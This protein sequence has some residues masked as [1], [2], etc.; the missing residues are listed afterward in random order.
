MAEQSSVITRWEGNKFVVSSHLEVIPGKQD[1]Y[2]AIKDY[3]VA[4]NM[5][6]T[7]ADFGGLKFY[8]EKLIRA[9]MPSGELFSAAL[10]G[11]SAD[12]INNSVADLIQESVPWFNFRGAEAEYI[13]FGKRR[14]MNMAIDGITPKTEDPEIKDEAI[15]SDAIVYVGGDTYQWKSRIKEYGKKHG[16]Y[17]KWDGRG[18]AWKIQHQAWVQ[19]VTDFPKLT[20]SLHLKDV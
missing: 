18:E 7:L 13:D 16:D 15:A 6:A 20:E 17:A 19:L 14:E 4:H 3:A 12:E 2:Q 8:A 10:I 11:N 1:R 5:K 9:D